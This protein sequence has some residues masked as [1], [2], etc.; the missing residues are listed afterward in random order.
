MRVSKRLRL[1][2]LSIF[3]G[4]LPTTSNATVYTIN[5]S[6]DIYANRNTLFAHTDLI[7]FDFPLSS[8]IILTSGDSIELNLSFTGGRSLYMPDTSF[9]GSNS[10]YSYNSPVPVSTTHASSAQFVFSNPGGSLKP[11]SDFGTPVASCCLNSFQGSQIVS[12]P[13]PVSFNGFLWRFIPSLSS[14]QQ[15]SVRYIVFAFEKPR[16]SARF[17]IAGGI[18]EP[19]IWAMLI[20]GFGLT[21]TALRR[22]NQSHK[23]KLALC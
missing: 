21:G 9:F 15:I 22:R 19:S 20:A 3:L 13:G 12:G 18:P 16:G 23:R 6:Y 11:I 1:L 17:S 10:I 2:L 5:Y 8:P 4:G 7:N 14:G